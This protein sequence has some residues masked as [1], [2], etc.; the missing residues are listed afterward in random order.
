MAYI[1]GTYNKYE[2]WDRTHAVHKFRINDNWYAV[3]EVDIVWGLP[4]LKFQVGQDD[5]PESYHIYEEQEDALEFVRELK[6][7]NAR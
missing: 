6:Q 1:I 7:L 5:M 4:A 2:T 3:Y